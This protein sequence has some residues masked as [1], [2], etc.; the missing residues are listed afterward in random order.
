MPDGTHRTASTILLA[1]HLVDAGR[2]TPSSVARAERMCALSGEALGSVLTRLGLI[3]E[4]DLADVFVELRG[5]ALAGPQ[6]YPAT[7]VLPGEMSR[8]Y[9]ERVRAIPTTRRVR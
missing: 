1:E 3:S 6:D 7:A 8:K 2:L 4:P 5:L 9:L